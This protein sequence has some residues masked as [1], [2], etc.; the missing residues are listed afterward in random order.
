MIG[1][2]KQAVKDSGHWRV[3]G[4]KALDAHLGSIHLQGIGRHHAIP[5]GDLKVGDIIVYNYGSTSIVREKKKISPKTIEVVVESQER[6]DNGKR[7]TR[8]YRV[9]RLVAVGRKK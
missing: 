6:S 9:D 3:L 5:A 2:R 7:Y 8:Q 1:Q 4:G